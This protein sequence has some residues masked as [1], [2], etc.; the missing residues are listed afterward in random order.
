MKVIGVFGGTFDPIHLGHLRCALEVV[1]S[2][3]LDE[4]RFIPAGR[5]PHRHAPAA[6]AALRRAMVAAAIA[7]EPRFLLDDRELRRGGP[8]YM[9]DTLASLREEFPHEALCLVLGLDA[10]TGLPAWH[11]W[12]TLFEQ[13]HIVVMRRPGAQAEFA[14][15]LARHVQARREE[16]VA[17]LRTRKAGKIFFQDVSQLGI[18][19]SDIR[20]RLARGASVRYLVPDAVFEILCANDCYR[21]LEVTR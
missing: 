8:S 4:M 10:F 15:P 18:S 7:G 20:A 14:T 13:A 9:T 6:D 19:A 1:E 5:P 21:S 17:G 12:E 16:S 11:R 2:L 3:S